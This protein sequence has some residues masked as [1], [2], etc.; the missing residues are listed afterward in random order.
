MPQQATVFRVLIASPSDCVHERRI[1]PDVIRAWNA[2]NSLRLAAIIEPVMWETH[3]R[4]ELGDRPQAVVNRQIVGDCDILVGTFWTRLGTPTG[5]AQSGTVEEIARFRAAGKPVML[6]FSSVPI[7][8]DSIDH[9]QYEL[10]VRY[11][12]DLRKEGLVSTYESEADFRDQFQRHLAAQMAEVIQQHL[13][14]GPIAPEQERRSGNEALIQI[15]SQ[16]EDFLRRFTFEWA[17]ERDSQPVAIDDGKFI[18]IRAYDDVVNLRSMIVSNPGGN[19]TGPLDEVAREL[20]AL[21]RHQLFMD[22]GMSFRA[23]WDGGDAVIARLSALLETIANQIDGQ[24][25]A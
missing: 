17:S 4:P 1:I 2:V 25:T 9:E 23:F 24:E 5:E 3:T 19:I 18:L 6:Y 12:E 22:G 7:V 13:K 11:R 21:S 10:L 15:R 14:T 20:R 8:P 16:L